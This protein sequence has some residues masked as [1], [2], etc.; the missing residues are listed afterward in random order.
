LIT[1]VLPG[2]LDVLANPLR[3]VSILSKEDL[4]TFERPMKAYSGRSGGGQA[5]NW[6][7][8]LKKRASRIS[9]GVGSKQAN[10]LN[11]LQRCPSKT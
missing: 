7:L 11:Q 3:D 9:I 8:L 1:C 4:P 6:V 2:V 10:R 5:D